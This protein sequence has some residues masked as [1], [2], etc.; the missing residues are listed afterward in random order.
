MKRGLINWPMIYNILMFNIA[1]LLFR[2][3][4]EYDG[5]D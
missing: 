1:G 3:K 5:D 4:S 2:T